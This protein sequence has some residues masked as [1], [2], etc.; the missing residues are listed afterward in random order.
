MIT[1]SSTFFLEVILQAGRKEKAHERHRTA[2]GNPSLGTRTD[3]ARELHAP[4]FRLAPR[5]TRGLD[6]AQAQHGTRARSAPGAPEEPA[7]GA[8]A[9]TPGQ[10]GR[11]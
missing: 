4:A 2:E 8:T 7:G 1:F 6:G 5:C 11:A 3:A 10:R 9:G